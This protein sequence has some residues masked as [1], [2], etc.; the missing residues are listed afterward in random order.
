MAAYRRSLQGRYR[1]QGE[2]IMNSREDFT[3]YFLKEPCPHPGQKVVIGQYAVNAAAL[4]DKVRWDISSIDI[5]VALAEHVPA[6]IW[7]EGFLG[8]IFAYPLSD[9]GGVKGPWI[10][11]LENIW[12]EVANGKQVLAFC[13][14]GHGRTGTFLASLIAIVEK[15]EDP[16]A[17]MRER[18]CQDAVETIYQAEA[19]FALVNQEI[20]EH[21]REELLDSTTISAMLEYWKTLK[22]KEKI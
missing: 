5:L 11:F 8:L 4:I 16:I 12:Q 10:K 17:T 22:S 19:I 20:P 13:E 2:A 21:Y 18:Y 3:N 15:P 1:Y 7:S 14:G 9:W 6:S